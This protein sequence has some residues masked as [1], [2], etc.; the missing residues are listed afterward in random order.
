MLKKILLAVLLSFSLSASA[1]ETIYL[2]YGFSP[3]SNL[4]NIYRVMAKELNARQ[5]KYDFVVDVRPGAG[6]A[7]AVNHTLQNP[8]N[9]VY[10]TSSTFF[11]RA[12]FDK[13]T[14]YSTDSFR[15][16]FVQGQGSPLVLMSKK[17]TSL[18]E[19]KSSADF[20]VSISGVG[21]ISHIMASQLG[22]S[23]PNIRIVNYPTLIDANRD[24]LGQHVD[25]GWNWLGDVGDLIASGAVNSL[26]ISGNN[27]HG[28]FNTL[29]GFENL[30][31]NAAIVA[32]MAMPEAKAEELYALFKEVNSLDTIQSMYQ[33][34]Y[35]SKANLSWLETRVWYVKQVKFWKQ[36]SEKVKPL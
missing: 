34:D 5:S 27:T 30:S 8:Q 24:I 35:Y 3:A 25:T 32:P 20:T 13:S 28:K 33:R 22:V 31:S 2:V 15:P 7:I 4:A 16:V 14:G 19:I 10:G 1:A 6:G 18:K 29:P 23:Y 17:Y 9:S 21:S 26:G 11:I 36:Q 12:N